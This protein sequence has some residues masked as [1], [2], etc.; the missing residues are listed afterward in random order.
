MVK[1]DTLKLKF[2]SDV[3]ED[4]NLD[5][6]YSVEKKTMEDD[7]LSKK[8]VLAKQSYLGLK[9]IEF[10]C[11]GKDTIAEGVIELSA[12]I[13]KQ[14]YYDLIN[15]NTIEQVV[16]NL[17]SYNFVKFD[18]YRFIDTVEVCRADVTEN[19]KVSRDVGE[20]ISLLQTCN[21]NP[22]YRVERYKNEAIV[23]KKNVISYKERMI[24]YDKYKELSKD[25]IEARLLNIEKFRNV[26]RCENNIASFDRLRKNFDLQGEKIFLKELLESKKQV[27]YETFSKIINANNQ[28]LMK[29]NSEE[30]QNMGLYQ[31]EKRLGQEFI[32]MCFDFDLNRVFEFLKSKNKSRPQAYN[33]FRQYKKIWQEMRMK[34]QENLNIEAIKEIKE[35]LRVA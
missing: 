19:L 22:K 30:F 6:F 9:N 14:N 20:Y 8:L 29:M 33:C 1:F 10:N 11:L 7:L 2:S 5:F 32:I 17:N 27:N 25:T 4:I 31:I 24:F 15:K 18:K 28:L 26:L 34:L 16:D 12:K 23:F 13:L 21:V 35:L 3:I